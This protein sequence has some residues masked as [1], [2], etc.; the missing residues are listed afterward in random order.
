MLKHGVDDLRTFFENDMR[1]LS[2]FAS[3]R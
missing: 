2:Q 1:F 3:G